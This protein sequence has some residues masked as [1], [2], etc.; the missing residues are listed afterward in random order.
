MKDSNF[1]KVSN[2]LIRYA[3]DLEL[4]YYDRCLIIAV[5]MH[6]RKDRLPYPSSKEVANILGSDERTVEKH[7]QRLQNRGLLKRPKGGQKPYWDFSGLYEALK[8][9]ATAYP[10]YAV[11][12]DPNSVLPIQKQHTSNPLTAY[13][14]YTQQR[15]PGTLEEYIEEDKYTHMKKTPYGVQNRVPSETSEKRRSFEASDKPQQ[16][17]VY[18]LSNIQLGEMNKLWTTSFRERD[19]KGPSEHPGQMS[20]NLQRIYE[21]VAREKVDNPYKHTLGILK[22]YFKE[23]EEYGVSKDNAWVYK[24]ERKTSRLAP[25][26]SAVWEDYW[27]ITEPLKEL[28]PSWIEEKALPQS[29]PNPQP[30]PQNNSTRIDA[31][32]PKQTLSKEQL[33]QWNQAP[34]EEKERYLEKARGYPIISLNQ[35]L[36]TY[37]AQKLYFKEHPIPTSEIEL[38]TKL[39]SKPP[40]INEFSRPT[41]RAGTRVIHTKTGRKGI[42]ISGFR[43]GST[44]FPFPLLVHERPD[45]LT[46]LVNR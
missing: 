25:N 3:K 42:V 17:S 16:E 18:V 28:K 15:T 36:V 43:P 9:V 29:T 41:F 14:Q 6:E 20:K 7:S 1:T 45:L 27:A 22:H 19:G 12:E 24:G 11:T 37:Q 38:P 26:F 13:S 32:S 44:L 39:A 10:Q 4:S 34:E 5:E 21:L 35:N 31:P 2:L 8:R 23:P 30:T 46:A 40:I 33:E